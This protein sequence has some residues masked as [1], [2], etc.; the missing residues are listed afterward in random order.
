MRLQT[1]CNY[2][3]FVL[4]F[5]AIVKFDQVASIPFLTAISYID[6]LEIEGHHER[7]NEAHAKVKCYSYC[8]YE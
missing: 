3:A 6:D 1:S 8:Q 7:R 4:S 2:I 5:D